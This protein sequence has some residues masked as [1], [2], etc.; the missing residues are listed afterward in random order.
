[1]RLFFLKP[2]YTR[3]KLKKTHC[4]LQSCVCL[5]LKSIVN[6][7]ESIIYTSLNN[8]GNTV[9][10]VIQKFSKNDSSKKNFLQIQFDTICIFHSFCYLDRIANSYIN[11]HLFIKIYKKI[12]IQFF[13]KTNLVWH[14]PSMLVYVCLRKRE[15]HT[16]T[17]RQRE[18]DVEW[19]REKAR[20]TKES[21]V[22]QC[23][24]E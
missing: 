18:I 6:E 24:F 7:L 12:I 4:L 13:N 17:K 2:S 21:F 16:E 5:L 3:V 14:I 11:G 20:E 8:F 23:I 19:G 1:M 9:G 10:I 22:L 15:R